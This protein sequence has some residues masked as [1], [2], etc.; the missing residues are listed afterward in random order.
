MVFAGSCPQTARVNGLKRAGK[1]LHEEQ[2]PY[3]YGFQ[4]LEWKCILLNQI[5]NNKREL[6]RYN[7]AACSKS[8][9]SHNRSHVILRAPLRTAMFIT[10]KLQILS[11]K[12]AY[13]CRSDGRKR[14]ARDIP[15]GHQRL[16]AMLPNNRSSKALRTRPLGLDFQRP[17]RLFFLLQ[18][19]PQCVRP[20]RTPLLRSLRLVGSL[21]RI[22]RHIAA[23]RHPVG[24]FPLKSHDVAED[25]CQCE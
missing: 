19:A 24:D 10:P 18:T 11:K 1:T 13:Q 5:I 20:P 21:L 6:Q 8:A 2:R 25:K 12:N 9:L 4:C 22:R 17:P 7:R 15:S 16:R 23:V 14:S 3:A